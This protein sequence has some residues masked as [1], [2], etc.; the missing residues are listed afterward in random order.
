MKIIFWYIGVI[1]TCILLIL[2]I[3]SNNFLITLL[4]L[5]LALILKKYI[6]KIP[7]PK[8]FNTMKVLHKDKK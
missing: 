2:S 1:F 6:N 4:S 5:I 7:L 8:Y 3:I